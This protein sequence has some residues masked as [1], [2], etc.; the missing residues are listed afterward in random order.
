MECQSE[1]LLMAHHALLPISLLQCMRGYIMLWCYHLGCCHALANPVRIGT[2]ISLC[3][4]V[5]VHGCLVPVPY[6]SATNHTV[7][8]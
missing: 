8:L 1:Q 3:D 2:K 5:L 4:A 7:C 6:D